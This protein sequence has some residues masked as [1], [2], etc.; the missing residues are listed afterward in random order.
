MKSVRKGKKSKEN[1]LRAW[2]TILVNKEE[3]VTTSREIE[4]SADLY[5]EQEESSRTYRYS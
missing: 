2:F 3:V 4:G 1:E 5:V